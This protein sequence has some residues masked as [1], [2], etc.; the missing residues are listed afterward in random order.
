[1]SDD[2]EITFRFGASVI[3]MGTIW[4]MLILSALEALFG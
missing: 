1:M 2:R 4:L 3:W